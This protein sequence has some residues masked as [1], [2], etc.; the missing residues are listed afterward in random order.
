M[1]TPV[2][3]RL[4]PEKTRVFGSGRNCQIPPDLTKIQTHSYQAFIQT[5]CPPE[6]R[7]L[8]GIEGVLQE[9]F[10]IESYDKKLS[11]SYVRY[12]LGKPR[13]TPE[14]CRQ[15]R[16]TYGQ[17]FRV[18]LR[19]EKEQPVEEEVFLGDIPIM[20]G[21]GEFI[22]NGA[23]RVVVSQLHRSPGIDFVMES[24]TTSDRKLASCRVIPERGSWIEV[25]ATKKDALTVRTVSY[26]HLTLPTIYSV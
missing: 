3:R 2:E 13:Y 8:Q 17:P 5:D 22:I 24:D 10:P 12:E 15:L 11:M 7:K 16:L 21:G 26:T 9:I 4:Q 19:L 20:L 25:N 18:W 14:E 1:A 6:K 23:E